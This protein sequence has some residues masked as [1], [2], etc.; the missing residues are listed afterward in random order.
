MTLELASRYRGSC[1]LVELECPAPECE[2]RMLMDSESARRLGIECPM[3]T[4]D[5]EVETA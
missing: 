4:C 3:P 2:G 5:R 1:D